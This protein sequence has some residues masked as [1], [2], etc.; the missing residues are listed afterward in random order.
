MRFQPGQRWWGNGSPFKFQRGSFERWPSCIGEISG[1]QSLSSEEAHNKKQTPASHVAPGRALS[2]QWTAGDDGLI[3]ERSHSYL[4]Q[5]NK[6]QAVN[7]PRFTTYVSFGFLL[8]SPSLAIKS[9]WTS[10]WFSRG[11]PWRLKRWM[12]KWFII[13][14]KVIFS[15]CISGRKICIFTYSA[16]L[17]K[18]LPINSV[19][20][21]WPGLK[22]YLQRCPGSKKCIGTRFPVHQKQC[23]FGTAAQM[24]SSIDFCE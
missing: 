9:T 20:Q 8:L 17:Y 6:R 12:F 10:V 4:L 13:E 24:L 15:Q 5:S 16:I 18:I 21:G 2:V 3:A 19:I 22:G 7:A 11:L 1:G 14:Y 23:E